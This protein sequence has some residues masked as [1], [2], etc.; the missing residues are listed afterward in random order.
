MSSL[1]YASPV[2]LVPGDADGVEA[3]A[4]R[5]GGFAQ[6]AAGAGD[7]LRDVRAG[8]WVGPAGD[9]FRAQV[10]D[11]PRQLD[12]AAASFAAAQR[13]LSSYA[14]VLREARGSAARAV[15]LHADG[16]RA[17]ARWQD[18]RADHARVEAA[19]RTSAAAVGKPD[20]GPLPG[21]P[22][23]RDPGEDERAAARRLLADARER[24]ADAGDAA[25]SRLRAAA[26]SAPKE[27]SLLSRAMHQVGQFLAG[28]GEATWGLLELGFTLSPAYALIDPESFVEHGAGLVQGLVYGVQ[29]PK[30]F[31]KAVL[32]WDTWKENPARA[33]GHLVPDLLLTLATAGAGAAG[34]GAR[35]LGAVGDLS[36]ARRGLDGGED[37][38]A[39]AQ[40]P[41]R[42][43]LDSVLEPRFGDQVARVVDDDWTPLGSSPDV[44]SFARD[45]I[46]VTGD[47][48]APTDWRWPD[49]A[50]AVPG[51]ERIVVAGPGMRVDRIGGKG[52][53]F[54]TDPG[55]PFSQR[56]LP[57][58]RLEL[59]LRDWEVRADH[60]ALRDGSVRLEVSEVAP[61]FGQP[62]GGLQYRFLDEKGDPIPNWQLE[63]AKV[64]KD[65]TGG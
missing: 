31:A 29:H 59:E 11:L 24:V 5:L 39:L 61:W 65:V 38:A 28:A 26:E 35:G 27:P 37:V 45:Y 49:N 9:A 63:N 16:D 42:A 7:Q 8:T 18:A 64:V 23:G 50:G 46:R 14:A 55:T 4:R 17:T 6:A 20:P 25:A 44:E 10:G 60:P 36:A 2:D 3:L 19:A 47:P 43:P 62:G 21:G 54:F 15:D 30:E 56:S 40:A 33:L 22:G 58:D 1:S 52:G 34:R 53:D 32:D 57:P 13:A 12:R 48:D 51:S 41:R